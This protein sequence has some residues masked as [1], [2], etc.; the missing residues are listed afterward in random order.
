MSR[1]TLIQVADVILVLRLQSTLQRL[2][3]GEIQNNT[4][5]III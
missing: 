2:L 5:Y 1:L 4:R 3:R